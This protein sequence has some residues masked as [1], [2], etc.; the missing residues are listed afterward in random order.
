MHLE[1]TN[2]ASVSINSAYQQLSRRAEPTRR[3]LTPATSN[4]E[5]HDDS[6]EQ[7]QTSGNAYA[8]QGRQNDMTPARAPI[9]RHRG[10][11]PIA[12]AS[13]SLRDLPPNRRRELFGD[14]VLLA[15]MPPTNRRPRRQ[16]YC[17]LGIEASVLDPFD[18]ERNRRRPP[19]I[20]RARNRA[21]SRQ[22]PKRHRARRADK[23]NSVGDRRGPRRLMTHPKPSSV[24]RDAQP[25]PAMETTA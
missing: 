12:A 7:G 18:A 10:R 23:R 4:R 11:S 21:T 15:R 13:A 3:H 25:P 6:D 8:G 5:N 9:D 22:P 20:R 24:K 16:H 17:W 1:R 2:E 19:T 14:R